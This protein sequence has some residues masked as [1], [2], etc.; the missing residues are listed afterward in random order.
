[1]IALNIGYV[2]GELNVFRKRPALIKV[3]ATFRNAL[4][5]AATQPIQQSIAF[6]PAAARAQINS[7]RKTIGR[8][9]PIDSGST[10]P[11]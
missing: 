6:P 9:Q 3:I 11:S 7:R 1:M 8:Y 4:S 2:G 10:Y 5:I